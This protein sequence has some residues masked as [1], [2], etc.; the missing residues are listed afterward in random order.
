MQFTDNAHLQMVSHES[1]HGAQMQADIASRR[2]F[3]SALAAS[4]ALKHAVL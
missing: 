2:L 4:Q 1:A 3:D